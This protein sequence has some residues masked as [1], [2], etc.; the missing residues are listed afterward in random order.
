M[1]LDIV[2]ISGKQG[3]GKTTLAHAVKTAIERRGNSKWAF[4]ELIF[5]GPIYDMHNA[6][7]KILTDAGVD[8]VHKGKDGNLLQLL[9]TE[10]GRKL[11]KDLWVKIVKGRVENHARAAESFGA[12]RLTILIPDLRFKNEFEA[13]PEALRVRLE[14]SEK[15]RRERILDTPGSMWRENTN[16]PSEI[17]LDVYAS[18]GMFD[19]HENTEFISSATIADIIITELLHETWGEKRIAQGVEV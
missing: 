14:C 1:K 18:M 15:V 17:D 10:W 5:A 6:C 4:A 11:D 8:P 13:F 19:V 9:G 16:H 2:P 12:E 3:S 7:R